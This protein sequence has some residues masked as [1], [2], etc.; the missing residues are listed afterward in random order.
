LIGPLDQEKKLIAG[1]IKI[2]KLFLFDKNFEKVFQFYRLK[3]DKALWAG[4]YIIFI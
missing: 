3:G 2:T 4:I 1:K